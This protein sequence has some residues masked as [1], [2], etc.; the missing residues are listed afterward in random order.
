MGLH[1]RI[2]SRQSLLGQT[3]ATPGSPRDETPTPTFASSTAPTP[4]DVARSL[5]NA[6]ALKSRSAQFSLI[7]QAA[8]RT[9]GLGRLA[10]GRHILKL[11]NFVAQYKPTLR[12]SGVRHAFEAVV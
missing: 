9:S 4:A 5:A 6:E 12:K 1:R 7:K 10:T 3:A 8:T 2:R 11:T